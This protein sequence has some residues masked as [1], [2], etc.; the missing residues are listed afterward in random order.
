[1]RAESHQGR[2]RAR[3]VAVLGLLGAL[4]LYCGLASCTRK[5]T[6]AANEEA[7]T[8]VVQIRV[9]GMSCAACAA[10]VKKALASIGGVSDVEVSLVERRARVRFDPGRAT[11]DQ[12]VAAIDGLG[13]RA[14]GPAEAQ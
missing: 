9:E 14:D 7:S 4:P 8:K 10:R 2:V 1:M 13:Y 12:L 3:V 6:P 11:P 5:V